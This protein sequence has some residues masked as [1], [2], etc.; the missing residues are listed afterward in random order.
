MKGNTKKGRS[1]VRKGASSRSALHL[2]GVVVLDRRYDR[3][4][5]L[6][7][8][9]QVSVAAYVRAKADQVLAT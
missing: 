2:H 3:R 9:E 4:Q 6:E 8:Q 7:E 1:R 5:E